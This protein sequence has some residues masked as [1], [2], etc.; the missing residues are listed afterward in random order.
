MISGGRKSD[1]AVMIARRPTPLTRTMIDLSILLIFIGAVVLLVI[2]PG[3]DMA[4]MLTRTIAQGR[5]AGALAA[6]GINAGAYVHVLASVLGLTAI[7]ATSSV[8]FTLIKW[9]GAGYLI[10]I[11]I[12]ALRSEVAPLAMHGI[13]GHRPD[14]SSIFWQGFISDVLNPKVAIFFLAFLPQFVNPHSE[15][16]SVTTQ[17]LV[18]GF[19]CN[20]V[21]LSVNLLLVRLAGFASASLR[22][23][24]RLTL[25]LHRLMGVVFIGLGLR[26]ANEKL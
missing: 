8:A 12:Q 17:L 19:T 7:L 15:S 3:P 9:A 11:G 25:W 23:N 2:T 26:L 1:K 13:E 5:R 4:F 18:L 21:A 6:L 20:I 24:Q 22:A 14:G 10:W 16:A